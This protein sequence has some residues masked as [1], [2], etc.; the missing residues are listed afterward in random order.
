MTSTSPRLIREWYIHSV[1][2]YTAIK[3][4]S[5]RY[6]STNE[7]R[8][9]RYRKWKKGVAKLV[10]KMWRYIYVNEV[11]TIN[12]SIYFRAKWKGQLGKFHVPFLILLTKVLTMCIQSGLPV[13][14]QILRFFSFPVFHAGT[15]LLEAQH[16]L[17]LEASSCPVDLR[18]F[19]PKGQPPSQCQA[20]T[21][22]WVLLLGLTWRRRDTSRSCAAQWDLPQA[23]LGWYPACPG[24]DMGIPKVPAFVRYSCVLC[25]CFL[26]MSVTPTFTSLWDFLAQDIHERNGLRP[27]VERYWISVYQ[28]FFSDEL[29]LG[30]VTPFV[31]RKPG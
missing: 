13:G 15:H 3:N 20:E 17:L 30:S 6:L 24:L 19:S 7:E 26:S 14:V 18:G 16:L 1:Q 23:L 31:N 28:L 8:Y 22:V 9:P 4:E 25:C 2:S 12:G 11:L 21:G 27:P 10:N 5:G 29:L